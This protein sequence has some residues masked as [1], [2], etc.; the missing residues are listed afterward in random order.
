VRV[1]TEARIRSILRGMTQA[2][3]AS[4]EMTWIKGY[5][6]L[7]NDA[8][9]VKVIEAVAFEVL[10]EG[11]YMSKREARLLGEDFASYLNV[12]PGAF[13][14]LG[15]RGGDNTDYPLHSPRFDIDERALAKGVDM[16]VGIAKWHNS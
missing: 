9:A 11:C 10:G 16:F 5:P 7:N 12:V 4:Y 2:H 14:F 6:V 15:T 13:F 3:N 8:E 1:V